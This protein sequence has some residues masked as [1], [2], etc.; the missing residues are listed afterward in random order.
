MSDLRKEI[1]DKVSNGDFNCEKELTLSVIGG[2]WKLIILW[3]LG[4]QGP[5]RFSELQRLL[6]KITHKMLTSQL[7]ELMDDGI[8]HREVFPEVPPRVE[9]SMTELG[10][11][12]LPILEMMY[13]WGKNRITDI[14]KMQEQPS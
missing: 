13:T 1:M 6:P 2:K 10:M 4:K 14:K 8:I 7:K 3:H 12:L 9:Y 5:Q 11:T